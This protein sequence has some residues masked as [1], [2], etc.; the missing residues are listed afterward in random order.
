M[1][2]PASTTHR[3]THSLDLPCFSTAN[4]LLPSVVACRILD[5]LVLRPFRDMRCNLHWYVANIISLHTDTYPNQHYSS[6]R[7]GG[8]YLDII[9]IF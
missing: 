5:S 4:G 6:P 2:L 9:L 3:N 7:D 8:I 1:F